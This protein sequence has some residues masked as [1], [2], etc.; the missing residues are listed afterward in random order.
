MTDDQNPLR[1]L[2]EHELRSRLEETFDG[3]ARTFDEMARRHALLLAAYADRCA[4]KWL[5]VDT[6]RTIARGD[7]R[8]GCTMQSHDEKPGGHACD[9]PRKQARF[10][11]EAMGGA[12]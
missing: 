9:C 6:L 7:H 2:M 4:E 11:V 1:R 10:A 8:A 5:L 3:I 12:T